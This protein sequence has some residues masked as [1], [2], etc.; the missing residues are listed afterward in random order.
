MQFSL[1][2]MSVMKR[3][4]LVL[5]TVQLGIL[6]LSAVALHSYRGQLEAGHREAVQSLGEIGRGVIAHF[7]ALEES[8]RMTRNEAQEAA[9]AAVRDLR[10]KGA[11][12]F[13]INDTRPVMVMHPARPELEGQD[14][15]NNQDPN[16]KYVFREFVEVAKRDGAG[17]V[18]YM[19][20]K[21]GYEEPQPKISF[22]A[23]YEP[24]NWVIGTGVYV[25]DIDQAFM[26][27]LSDQAVIQLLLMAALLVLAWRVARSI[28]IQLGGEPEYAARVARQ[29]AAGELDEK[30]AVRDGDADSL[31]AALSAAQESVHQMALD[32]R[33][34]VDAAAAGELATR[35]DAARH[36]GEYRE[37]VEGVNATLDAVIGPLNV[38]AGYVDRISN[39]DIPEKI[40]DEYKGD[41]NALKKNLNT[42]IDAV[43]RLV[44]DA[45][46]LSDAALAG[47]LATR[48]DAKRHEGDFRKIV[49]GVNA[50]LDAVVVPVNEVKRVMVALSEGDLTQK[51]QGNY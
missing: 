37:I 16:G 24:W 45:N 20:P 40:T 31:L 14:L 27:H 7:H 25:D 29:I 5:V 48:A 1:R 11:E 41:F 42:C 13:W 49:E 50:T 39:G 51:I 26:S 38:A 6:L 9:K 17:I 34:L 4:V 43:N 15:S 35:A 46:M 18:E 12:Y 3:Q 32:T 44:K 23:F 21:P 10:Y 36:E 47:Q 2:S 30:V 22:V 28:T 8:G 33:K 19:W